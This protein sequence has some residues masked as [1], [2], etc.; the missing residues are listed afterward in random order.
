MDSPAGAVPSKL[1]GPRN[2]DDDVEAYLIELGQ[3]VRS[4]RAVR[5]T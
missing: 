4:M 2:R 5:G 1:R 3:R